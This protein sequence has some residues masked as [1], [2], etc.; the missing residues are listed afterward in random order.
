MESETAFGETTRA[1]GNLPPPLP[2]PRLF[3]RFRHTSPP[4]S[5]DLEELMVGLQCDLP[6][7]LSS[8]DEESGSPQY[9]LNPIGDDDA[10][11]AICIPLPR[12]VELSVL[13]NGVDNKWGMNC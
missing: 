6:C 10:T 4:K 7:P 3:S 13:V 11:V 9:F 5:S 1:A 8:D 2:L 12:R